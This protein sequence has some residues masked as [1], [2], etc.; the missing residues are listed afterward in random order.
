MKHV[1]LH[2]PHGARRGSISKYLLICKIY[3]GQL[4]WLHIE[5]LLLATLKKNTNLLL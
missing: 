5:S 3:Q 2:N 4:I 1:W